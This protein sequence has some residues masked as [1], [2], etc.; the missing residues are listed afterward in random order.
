MF[1]FL[2]YAVEGKRKYIQLNCMHMANNSKEITTNRA[3]K[4]SISCLVGWL[5]VSVTV[6][7]LLL[8]FLIFF[9]ISLSFA[10]PQIFTQSPKNKVCMWVALHLDNNYVCQIVLTLHVFTIKIS[11]D[12]L[13]I[14][15]QFILTLI[16]MQYLFVLIAESYTYNIFMHLLFSFTRKYV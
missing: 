1:A 14:K 12:M 11:L 9:L 7:L 10:S 4:K 6:L 3:K 13:N 5:A 15:L 2:R 16:T 8:F